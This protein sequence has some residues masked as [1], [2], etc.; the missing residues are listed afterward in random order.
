MIINIANKTFNISVSTLS[1]LIYSAIF[2]GK[3]QLEIW[4]SYWYFL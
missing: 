4:Y 3:F 2:F 1:P